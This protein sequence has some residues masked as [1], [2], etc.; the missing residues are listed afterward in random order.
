MPTRGWTWL[1][2]GLALVFAAGNTINALNKGGDAAV[3]FEGGRRLLQG[4]PL[5]EDSSTASGF[6]GPP[7]QALF[8]AP[9]AALGMASPTAAKL[10]WYA[11]NLACL[12]VAVSVTLKTWTT[13]VAN[14]GLRTS[15]TWP[16][17]LAPIAAVILPLQTNFEHQN[18]N[19]VLLALIA[20][21]TWHVTLGSAVAAGVLV[22]SAT[23]LKAFPVLL[24]MYFAVRR[25]WTALG[26]GIA[27]TIALTALPILVYEP[28]G[29]LQLF[30]TWLALGSGG[31]P[32][33]GN[34]QSLIAALDRATGA[35]GMSGVRTPMDAPIA[36]MLFVVVAI[37]LA[38][39]A[40]IVIL[41][42]RSEPLR[43]SCEMA[44]MTVLAVLLAPIAWDH[45]WT[46]LFPAFFFVYQSG[47]PWLLG[48]SG[49][50]AFW[51]AA[52]LTSG[53][54]PLTLGREG[55]SLA[56]QISTST[57]AALV[58]YGA[59]LITCRGFSRASRSR[60]G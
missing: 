7:F 47:S 10:L 56:R 55:F 37:A 20:G 2:I 50:I 24:L 30:R 19:A 35:L 46:L 45:Y 44:A 28:S 57:L 23:A 8:F 36:S 13:A 58:L 17:L 49:Q 18:M 21:A 32:I 53:A 14:R 11:L 34:N 5:Y 27:A 40:L 43:V 15:L 4:A 16:A 41:A 60:Q 38:I 59:L 33:R 3:L 29:F 26:A 48:R 25:L 39:A 42:T 9:F 51:A 12:G 1:A 31:W 6:I 54:S 22:G 52:V